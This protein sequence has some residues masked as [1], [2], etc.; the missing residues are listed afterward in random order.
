VTLLYLSVF[1]PEFLYVTVCVGEF[2]V[3]FFWRIC[4]SPNCLI[5][6]LLTCKFVMWAMS[7]SLNMTL[8]VSLHV[9]VCDIACLCM[10]LFVTLCLYGWRIFAVVC[11]TWVICRWPVSLSWRNS[12]FI[13]QSF[14]SLCSTLSGVRCHN[15]DTYC[16]Q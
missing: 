8:H 9:C 10:C 2:N 1:L 11:A 3:V 15:S 13:L 16:R 6:L 5:C 4:H 14:H 12:T 7:A